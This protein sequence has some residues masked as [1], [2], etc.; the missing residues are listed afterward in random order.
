MTNKPTTTTP[1]TLFAAVRATHLT[2]AE[3]LLE[4]RGRLTF[5]EYGLILAQ[6]VALRADCTRRRVG[7]V[8]MDQHRRVVGT[9]Y[10]GAPPGAP[11][12]LSSGACPRGQMSYDQVP[13]SSTYAGAL[14]GV[15]CIALH[16]EENAMLHSDRADRS[17]ATIYVTD[18]PCPNCS[19]ILAGSGLARV[20][21][22]EPSTGQV[23][24]LNLT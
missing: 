16:A 14:G 20:V 12:C 7:A 24:A 13:K 4:A 18:E 17:G 23:K 3:G 15:N 11:G 19:R 1:S 8:I 22:V 21:W 10:N 6:T 5:D 9:G 2:A